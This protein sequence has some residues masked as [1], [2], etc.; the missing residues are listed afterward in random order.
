MACGVQEERHW[1]CLVFLLEIFGYLLDAVGWKVAYYK[2]LNED[3][4][5]ADKCAVE[6]YQIR[7]R[8]TSTLQ[9]KEKVS[10]AVGLGSYTVNVG[11]PPQRALKC[12]AQQLDTGYKWDKLTICLDLWNGRSRPA[13]ME[14]HGGAFVNIERHIVSSCIRCCP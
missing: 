2:F 8:Y 1:L 4:G 13:D 9:D 14:L 3:C 10:L 11:I 5:V 12:Y 6:F 7:C